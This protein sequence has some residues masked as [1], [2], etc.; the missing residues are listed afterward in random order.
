M[1]VVFSKR[2]VSFH[3]TTRIFFEGFSH[4]SFFCSGFWLCS[5]FWV[6]SGFWVGAFVRSESVLLFVSLLFFTRFCCFFAYF[7][8]FSPL[9][10][11]GLFFLDFVWW[12]WFCAYFCSKERRDNHMSARKSA[13]F[14]CD[15]VLFLLYKLH[16]IYIIRKTMGFGF[17]KRWVS[18]HKTTRIFFEGFSHPSFFVLNSTFFPRFHLFRAFGLGVLILFLIPFLFA[19]FLVLFGGCCFVC[20]FAANKHWRNG[21]LD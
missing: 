17:S 14:G 12:F 5:G 1:G 13:G 20:T 11:C 2:W 10:L 7:F 19:F 16:V 18:F 21:Y 3:K 6:R 9:F 15:S 4:P 8:V